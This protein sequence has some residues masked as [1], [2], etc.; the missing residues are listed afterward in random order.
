MPHVHEAG[1][2]MTLDKSIIL[3]N[4]WQ[5]LSPPLSKGFHPEIYVWDSPSQVEHS[6]AVGVR[7]ARLAPKINVAR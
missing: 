1:D 6:H 2:N 5:F 4:T 7:E 3:D